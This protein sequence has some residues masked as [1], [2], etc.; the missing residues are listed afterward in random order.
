M[1]PLL[2]QGPSLAAKARC[3]EEQGLYY[4]YRRGKK[5]L[6][7]VTRFSILISV[8]VKELEAIYFVIYGRRSIT[9]KCNKS[10]TNIS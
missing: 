3:P 4:L 2:A 9:H 7:Q 5:R 8:D 1:A 10:G 6:M